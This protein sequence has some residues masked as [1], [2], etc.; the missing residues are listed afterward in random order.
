MVDEALAQ[1][2]RTQQRVRDLPSR[3]VVYLL[4]A[5]AL[6]PELGWRQ[7]WQ[8]LTAGLAG[9]AVTAPTAGALAQ[10]RRRVGHAPLRWLVDLLRGPA[11]GIA[12][13]GAHWRGLLA[14]AIDGTT[15]SVAD[16]PANLRTYAKQRCN[17]GGAGYPALRM[18]ALLCCGTRTL[19]DAVYGPTAQIGR[20]SCRE[21]A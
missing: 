2:C 10:A 5:G 12:T 3:V 4:L 19:I 9:M 18:L 7:V 8:R 21:R 17:S 20:A 15:M 1:T 14:C 6:F 11:P 13:P 16:S